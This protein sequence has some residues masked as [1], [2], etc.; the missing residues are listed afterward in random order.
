MKIITPLLIAIGVIGIA[1]ALWY[2]LMMY[3]PQWRGD[4]ARHE[5][6]QDYRMEYLDTETNTTVIKPIDDLYRQC[7]DEKGL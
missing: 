6:A 5:C 4:K 7:L 3:V 1:A 2:G